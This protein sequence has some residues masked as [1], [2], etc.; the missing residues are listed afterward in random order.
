MFFSCLRT[1]YIS[2][3]EHSFLCNTTASSNKNN[4]QSLA[5]LAQTLLNNVQNY[6]E[7]QRL[8][9]VSEDTGGAYCPN[10][11]CWAEGEESGCLTPNCASCVPSV[12]TGLGIRNV[13]VSVRRSFCAWAIYLTSPLRQP[14]RALMAATRCFSRWFTRSTCWRSPF[15]CC[16][17]ASACFFISSFW[18]RFTRS[19]HAHCSISSLICFV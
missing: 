18:L 6:K 1:S 14:T 16:S 7:N 13:C 4:S 11:P 17:Y 9:G 15:A 12:C 19:S 5:H 8:N 2:S 10:P 3:L